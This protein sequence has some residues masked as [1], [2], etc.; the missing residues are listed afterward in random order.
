MVSDGSKAGSSMQQSSFG[1]YLDGI[2]GWQRLGRV[3]NLS[4]Q[5]MEALPP[6]CET[7]SSLLLARLMLSECRLDSGTRKESVH[8]TVKMAMEKEQ[9]RGQERCTG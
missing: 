4:R 5:P 9:R 6:V 3:D 1:S 7:K 8:A 2:P